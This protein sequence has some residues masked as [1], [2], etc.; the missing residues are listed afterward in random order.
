MNPEQRV[1][2]TRPF[3]LLMILLLLDVKTA[4]GGS[5]LTS[6]QRAIDPSCCAD[7]VCAVTVMIII[8]R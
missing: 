7:C 8:R 5:C 2:H 1:K 4:D 3:A 6:R